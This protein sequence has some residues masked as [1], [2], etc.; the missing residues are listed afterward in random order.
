M[1]QQY[2]S[3]WERRYARRWGIFRCVIIKSLTNPRKGKRGRL[4]HFPI[5]FAHENPKRAYKNTKKN[6]K[7]FKLDKSNAVS[8][9]TTAVKPYPSICPL[10]LVWFARYWGKIYTRHLFSYGGFWL[11]VCF[12]LHLKMKN[13]YIKY[14][15]FF[16]Q[17]WCEKATP[18]YQ[19]TDLQSN[20]HSPGKL[21]W[22]KQQNKW[23]LRRQV[24]EG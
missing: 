1:K 22:V 11:P 4:V 6:C 16:G 17:I 10:G 18:S 9:G 13:I 12:I 21:R 24:N 3:Y 19:L 15:V 20:V 7:S 8:L 23:Y 5:C 2:P 14:I